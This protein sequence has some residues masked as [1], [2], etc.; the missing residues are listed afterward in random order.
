MRLHNENG[1][2][3]CSGVL[4][5][6]GSRG[7][8][9]ADATGKFKIQLQSC[10]PTPTCVLPI[11]A[12]NVKSQMSDGKAHVTVPEPECKNRRN[13]LRAVFG[14]DAAVQ[15]GQAKSDQI[16]SCFSSVPSSVYRG[17][18]EFWLVSGSLHIFLRLPCP[19]P[20]LNPA[21][22]TQYPLV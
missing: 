4:R 15:T 18:A 13:S 11:K 7:S 2:W 10:L 20:L 3:T 8:P 17:K 21:S 5:W 12:L 14:R 22:R 6:A 19:H 9:P 1:L 16:S